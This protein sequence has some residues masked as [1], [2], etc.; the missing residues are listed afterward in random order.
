MSL[1]IETRSIGDITVLSCTGHIVEGD[2]SSVLTRAV[3]QLL[4]LQPYVV[5]DLRGVSYIDS[6]GIGLLLRLRTRAQNAAGDVKICGAS[7]RVREVL[8]VTKLEGVLRPYSSHEE[9]IAAFYSRTEAPPDRSSLE[10]DVVFVHPSDDVLAYGRELLK[11]A[12]YGVTTASNVSDARVLVRATQPKVVVITPDLHAMLIDLDADVLADVQVLLL[13]GDFS[14]EEPGDAARQLLD[15][16]SRAFAEE[17][18]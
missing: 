11:R 12:G 1:S 3:E 15:S 10:I 13:P 9:A 17:G 4:P 14:H 8:R 18:A 7:P 2:D 5:L 16:L 6:S